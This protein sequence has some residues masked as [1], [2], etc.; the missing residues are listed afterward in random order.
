MAR[1]F[2]AAV[3]TIVLAAVGLAGRPA[4][5][6]D[7]DHLITE[8]VFSSQEIA[9]NLSRHVA[10]L[11][12]DGPADSVG[13]LIEVWEERNGPTGPVQRARSLWAMRGGVFDPS[14]IDRRFLSNLLGYRDL[15]EERDRRDD[16]AWL[17]YLHEDFDPAMQRLAAS[18][19][20]ATL[21][22]R[23]AE[24][25]LLI[26]QD[27][28]AEFRSLVRSERYRGCELQ[29]EY[30]G[31]VEAVRRQPETNYVYFIGGTWT[32]TDELEPIGTHAELLLGTAIEF[33]RGLLDLVA[34]LRPGDASEDVSFRLGEDRITTSRYVGWGFHVHAGWRVMRTRRSRI[35]ALV[36]VG[37]DS[38][39]FFF[40]DEDPPE[41]S[42]FLGIPLSV[43]LRHRYRF[44][45]TGSFSLE[46]RLRVG[47]ANYDNGEGSAFT[48]TWIALQ[49]GVGASDTS[50]YEILS[51]LD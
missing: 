36:G 2:P 25:V 46:T 31:L 8:R 20:R 47:F 23:S 35:D 40:G 27:R 45:D 44:R 26:Y 13:L 41:N 33:D 19:D 39:R 38:Q 50:K 15:A 32:P 42:D 1:S 34:L 28:W 10:R 51:R 14:R 17:P 5:A 3:A 11:L 21:S 49:V 29:V 12:A 18:I 43:G 7:V 37:V 9:L 30:E 16:G 4:A 24:L 22:S 6:Q 48:G